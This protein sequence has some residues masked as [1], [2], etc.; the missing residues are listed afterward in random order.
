MKQIW[1]RKLSAFQL[2]VVWAFTG[3]SKCCWTIWELALHTHLMQ[4]TIILPRK[5]TY[6]ASLTLMPCGKRMT[7]HH[8]SSIDKNN[9]I[10]QGTLR[11]LL[12]EPHNRLHINTCP[13]C[14]WWSISHLKKQNSNNIIFQ[15]DFQV[16]FEKLWIW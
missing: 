9:R 15:M 14:S 6:A 8:M 2:C 16:F 4:S 12:F 3:C 7:V 5:L 10:L 11:K 13:F 1:S